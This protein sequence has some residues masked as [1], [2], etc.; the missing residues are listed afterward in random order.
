MV[1]GFST[2]ETQTSALTQ[3]H[4]FRQIVIG[5][6][7][8]LIEINTFHNIILTLR[9]IYYL[10]ISVMVSNKFISKYVISMRTYV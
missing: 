7:F 9:S 10:M 3:L 1:E 4:R 5:L 8:E 2:N 6:A